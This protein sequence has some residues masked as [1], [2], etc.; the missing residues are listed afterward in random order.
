MNHGWQSEPTDGS[1]GGWSVGFSIWLSISPSFYLFEYLSNCRPICQYYLFICQSY[2]AICQFHLSIYLVI[3]LAVYVC[4]CVSSVCLFVH[5]VCLS[6][7]SSLSVYLS[8][9]VFF[10]LVCFFCFSFFLFCFHFFPSSFFP[11]FLSFFPSINLS[12]CLSVCNLS[13]CLCFFPIS[14]SRVSKVLRL[15]PGSE[16]RPYEVLQTALVAR[17]HFSK[18][19][20]SL[21]MRLAREIHLCTSPSNL[22]GLHRF[23]ELLKKNSR[24]PQFWQGAESPNVFPF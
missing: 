19:K 24:F 23:S 13:I 10:F 22:L 21:V 12:V 16:A 20:H 9:H 18:K 2:L 14:P 1:K 7:M 11:S 8:I 4:T 17:C 6:Y 3:Y 15:P 5:L